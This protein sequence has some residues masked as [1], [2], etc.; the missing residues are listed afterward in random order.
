M[1]SVRLLLGI[2]I[3]Y[4]IGCVIE[5][6]IKY[7]G[8]TVSRL[9]EP[10]VDSCRS[11]CSS[12]GAPYFSYYDKRMKCTCKSTDAGRIAKDGIVSGETSCDDTLDQPTTPPATELKSEL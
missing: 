3:I 4:I 7:H 5:E 11:S 2:N 6:N 9:E 8:N 10:D 1:V 12:M